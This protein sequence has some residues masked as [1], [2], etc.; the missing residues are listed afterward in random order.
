MFDKLPYSILNNMTLQD[1][2]TDKYKIK[3]EM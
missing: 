3:E 1:I 2:M